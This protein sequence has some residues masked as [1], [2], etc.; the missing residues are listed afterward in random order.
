MK[1]ALLTTSFI[2]AITISNFSYADSTGEFEMGISDARGNTDNTTIN[3]RMDFDIDQKKWRHNIFGYFFYAK[4]SGERSAENCTIGYKPRFFVT[5]QDYLFGLIRYGQD[6]FGSIEHQTTG[7]AG[8]G[9]QLFSINKHTLDAELGL[10]GRQT[11]YTSSP[12]NDKLASDELIYFLGGKYTGHISKTARFT[13]TGRV[14]A[15]QDNNYITSITSLGLSIA[16]NLSAKISY[17][18]RYNTDVTGDKGKKVDSLSNVNL[19]YRF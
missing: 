9:R 11:I 12:S 13:E 8:Y 1:N 15:G 6:K 5:T 2:A 18:L 19:V 4:N 7:V 10:G 3:A 17:T 14:E 16:G